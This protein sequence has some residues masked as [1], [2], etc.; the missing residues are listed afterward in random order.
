MKSPKF[1][2]SEVI[3]TPNE[4]T[5]NL[6]QNPDFS[7]DLSGPSY[8]QRRNKQLK[9]LENIDQSDLKNESE[10]YLYCQNL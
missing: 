4:K 8:I 9:D 3:L 2:D 5:E 10:M 1:G 6:I 7:N